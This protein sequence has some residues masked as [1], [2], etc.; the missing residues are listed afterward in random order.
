MVQHERAVNVVPRWLIL[1]GI[2]LVILIAA[3]AVTLVSARPWLHARAL[4]ML[5]NRFQGQ[6]EIRDFHISFFPI[7]KVTGSGIVIRHHGRTDVPPLLEISEFSASATLVGLLDR[8]LHTVHVKN[9]TIHFPPKEQRS[10]S[11]SLKNKKIPV[12][13]DQLISDDAE[14]DMMPGNPDKPTH[15]FLIHHL[16]IHDLGSGHPAPFETDLTNAAPPGEIHV[17]GDFG[18]WEE[19]DPR[20]T[21]VSANYTFTNADLSVFKG[22]SGI[23]SSTGKFGGPLE[24]LQVDGE[25]VTPDFAVDSG[26][27]P[28]MLKTQFSATV[29]GT[30]GDTLLHPVVARLADSTLV[31][32]GS[33]VRAANGKGKEVL[34]EVTSNGARI[35]DLLYLA[36][37]GQQ[38]PMTGTVNLKTKFDLPPASEGGGKVVDRLKLQGKFGIGEVQFTN[39]GIRGKIESLSDRA[40]GHPNDKHEDDPLSQLKGNFALGGGVITMRNLGF[41][42]PGVKVHLDGT[43]GLRSEDLDFHGLAQLQAKPSQ[44]VTGFKSVFLKLVDPFFRKNGVT[45]VPIKVTGKREHPSFGLDFHHKKEEGKEKPPDEARNQ[46][47][48]EAKR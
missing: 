16:V 39:P 17:K 25:T 12:L 42:V 45:Q 20:T 23:L 47:K 24:N 7:P 36:V 34:L 14:L 40:Q 22:I 9:L 41:S 46:Q 15:Q 37:K 19:D 28:M 26:G 30:N 31:C 6:V 8:H 27:H 35:Q 2:A 1:G 10:Q 21:P 18:P 4:A 5:Q 29:D 13:I 48:T 32:D 44:M 11:A 3:A 38:S 33:I 43:Y